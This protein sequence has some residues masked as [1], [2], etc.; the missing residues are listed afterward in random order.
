MVLTTLTTP[1]RITIRSLGIPLEAKRL[2]REYN[3]DSKQNY[4]PAASDIF[5]TIPL[6]LPVMFADPSLVI[7]LQ[8]TQTNLLCPTGPSYSALNISDSV[9]LV[10]AVRQHSKSPI[11]LSF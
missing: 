8:Q 9:V 10:G 1:L 3:S 2:P 7:T 5:L 4:P 11:K 6:L